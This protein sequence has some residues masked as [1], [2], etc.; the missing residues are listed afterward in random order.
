MTHGKVRYA[1]FAAIDAILVCPFLSKPFQKLPHGHLLLFYLLHLCRHFSTEWIIITTNHMPGYRGCLCLLFS[2]SFSSVLWSNGSLKEKQ[3]KIRRQKSAAHRSHIAL[4]WHV[5]HVWD[6][7]TVTV[8]M[9]I[10]ERRPEDSGRYTVVLSGLPAPPPT[11]E[12]SGFRDP[13]VVPIKLQNAR[14]LQT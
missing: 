9:T 8:Q 11:E 14:K 2:T 6:S 13:L 3:A 7:H 10:P 4:I 5:P 12:E 1:D